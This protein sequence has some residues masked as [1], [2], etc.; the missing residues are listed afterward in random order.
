MTPAWFVSNLTS[1]WL[2]AL[3]LVAAAAV[4][5]LACRI[6]HPRYLLY[7]RQGVLAAILLLPAIQPWPRPSAESAAGRAA[8]SITEGEDA[9]GPL[10]RGIPWTGIV[11]GTIIAG[12][13]LRAAWLCLGALRLRAILRRAELTSHEG[14]TRVYRSADIATPVTFGWRDPVVLLPPF[15]FSLPA[16]E[17]EAILTHELLHVERTDWPVAIGEEAIR[18]LLWFHPA[19]WWHISRI[20]L[21]REHTVDRLVIERG[22]E[23]DRYAE[24]LL[25]AAKAPRLAEPAPANLFLKKRHL[26]TRVAALYE[27]VNMTRAH[28]YSSFTFIAAGLAFV[29]KVGIATFPLAAPAQ[30][31]VRGNEGLLHRGPVSYPAEALEAKVEGTVVVQATLDAEGNVT[32]ARVISGPAALR[33][34]ALRSVLEW[35]Y[36]QATNPRKQVDIAIDFKLPDT[37]AGP[38]SNFPSRVLANMRIKSFD[39]SNDV[40]EET[41]QQIRDGFNPQTGEVLNSDRL[42]Q[43][44]RVV[45]SADSH[46]VVGLKKAEGDEAS[47]TVTYGDASQPKRIRV[48]G[49]VQAANLVTK[50]TPVYPPLAKQARI[51]GTVQFSVIIGKDGHI[52]TLDLVSGHPLLAPSATEAVRQWVYR[53][54]LLNGNPVEVATVIDVNFTLLP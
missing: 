13:A 49:N 46:L 39:F 17:R 34:A 16:D 23:A 31:V 33:R 27:E 10:G 38:R 5:E 22:A 54:T 41:R 25:S 35:H 53:P 28:L 18:S 9:G 32:D 6:R 3:M 20:Q 7:Y 45:K 52:L 15:Y 2:Q 29:M 26:A 1:Y 48:G 36:S 37:P 14:A 21:A 24:A 43:L 11:L 50:V 8:V 44:Q 40:K 30:E 47:I 19:V 42:E 51:Q 12:A 4:L